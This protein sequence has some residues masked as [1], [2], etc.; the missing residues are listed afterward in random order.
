M[1]PA[2]ADEVFEHLHVERF[3]GDQQQQAADTGSLLKDF[4]A[5]QVVE[6]W[7]RDRRLKHGCA[8]YRCRKMCGKDPLWIVDEG[9]EM[10]VVP[11]ERTAD[12]L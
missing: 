10:T 7:E 9:Q 4:L 2:Q 12:D 5:Y 11:V 3:V 1:R 8:L 6:Q